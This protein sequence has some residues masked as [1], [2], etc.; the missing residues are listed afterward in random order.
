MPHSLLIHPR[1]TRNLH[2]VF[3]SRATIQNSTITYNSHNEAVYNWVDDPLLKQL[4]CYIEPARGGEQ[5]Q[6]GNT[7]ITNQWNVILADNYPQIS[8]QQQIVIDGIAY[9]IVDIATE[10]TDTITAIVVERVSI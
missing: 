10:A 4:P 3:N 5:R 8:D 6:P 2:N 9:N 1:L 7:I